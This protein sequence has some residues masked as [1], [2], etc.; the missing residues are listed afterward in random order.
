MA[1][2]LWRENLV[3]VATRL[4]FE[5]PSLEEHSAKGEVGLGKGQN[6]VYRYGG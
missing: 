5:L 1:Q 2:W 6:T 3:T 4:R